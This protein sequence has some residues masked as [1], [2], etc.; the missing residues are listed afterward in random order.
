M[1]NADQANKFHLSWYDPGSA[2]TGWCA[3][4]VDF[5]AFSRPEN[6]VQEYL[7]W[8]DYGEFTGTEHEQMSAAVAQVRHTVDTWGENIP[9][10]AYEVGGEDFD[11]VQTIGSKED[12]L[13]PVRFNAVMRWEC[14][15]V[16]INYRLQNRSLRTSVTRE[17]L[18]LY[19]M[20]KPNHR[21]GKDAFAA[22]QHGVTRL[23]TIKQESLKRP[24]K[25]STASVRNAYWDCSCSSQALNR[26]NARRKRCDLLHPK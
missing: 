12:L 25:L 13:S 23:K 18:R 2:A 5:R 1:V 8:F 4:I 3:F 7:N 22:M 26:Y 11:L 14:S 15:K 24:W 20:I 17:R 10:L 6:Y 16:G 9:Y 21:M 19:D